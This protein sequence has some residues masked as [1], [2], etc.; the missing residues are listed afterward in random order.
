VI[1]TI[2]AFVC[3]TRNDQV[4][5]MM[6]ISDPKNLTPRSSGIDRYDQPIQQ[7]RFDGS[8]Y[9]D[10]SYTDV[11]TVA[12]TLNINKTSKRKGPRGGVAVPFPVRLHMMLEGITSNQTNPE[13]NICIASIVSWQPHGR[14]FRIHDVK[15]FVSLVMPR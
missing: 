5:P 3:K 4:R 12:R 11:T 6:D 9:H 13:D 7:Y 15:K 14:S 8:V 1:L 10:C 2:K